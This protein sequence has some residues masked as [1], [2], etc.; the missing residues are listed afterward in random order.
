[1]WLEFKIYIFKFEV[2]NFCKVWTIKLSQKISELIGMELGHT[3][4]RE[5]VSDGMFYKCANLHKIWSWGSI[6][7]EG[8]NRAIHHIFQTE[9]FCSFA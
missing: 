1:V 8:P 9:D 3:P 4:K 5:I 6:C 2:F 7:F